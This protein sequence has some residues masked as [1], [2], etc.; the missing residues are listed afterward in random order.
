MTDAVR[1][2]IVQIKSWEIGAPISPTLRHALGLTWP[3]SVGSVTASSRAA[4]ICVGPADWLVLSV[5]PD[6]TGLLSKL[7]GAF[8]DTTF[9]YAD[10]SSALTRIPVSGPHARALLSKGC[11]L[12]LNADNFVS[13]MSARTRFADMAVILRCLESSAFELILASSYREYLQAWLADAALEF[14]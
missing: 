3:T 11:S 1:S 7:A 6:D 13:G 12:D 5:T 10:M 2:T 9:R 4:V 14:G 8:V